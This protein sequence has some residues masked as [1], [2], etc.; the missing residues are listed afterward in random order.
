MP[1]KNTKKGSTKPVDK[2]VEEKEEEID[3]IAT[4]TPKKGLTIDVA[5]ILP[6]ADEKMDDESTIALEDEDAEDSPSLDTEDLN[7]FG[8]KWEE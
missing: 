5:D 8:D 2:V 6:E 3:I 7:P 4:G 1:V